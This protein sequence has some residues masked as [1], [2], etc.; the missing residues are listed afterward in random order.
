[1]K[2]DKSV[3]RILILRKTYSGCSA[4]KLDGYLFTFEN[5]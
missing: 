2:Q 5:S 1:M 4:W 3:R